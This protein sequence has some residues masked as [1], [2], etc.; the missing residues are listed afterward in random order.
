MLTCP[1]FP[2]AAVGEAMEVI[3]RVL[4]QNCGVSV[5]RAVTKLRA[6]HAAAY[7][8]GEKCEMGI[9]GISGECDNMQTLGLYEPFSVKIQTIKTSIES[10]CMILRIDDIVSG[11]KQ[12]GQ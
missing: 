2:F 1:Q 8:K 9:N 7:Q 4:A 3:P 5:V 12:A 10:A 6:A 11:S